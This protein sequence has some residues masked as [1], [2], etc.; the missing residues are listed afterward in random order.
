M[1]MSLLFMKFLN[2][3]PQDLKVEEYLQIDTKPKNG[4]RNDQNL[5]ISLQIL[6][7]QK[8]ETL[9]HLLNKKNESLHLVMKENGK[10][11]RDKN[12]KLNKK[13]KKFKE[14]LV[15]I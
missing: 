3:S 1:K 13:I 15:I 14:S 6:K 11:T 10:E 4:K 8:E 7:N 2:R 12:K 9:S 5:E